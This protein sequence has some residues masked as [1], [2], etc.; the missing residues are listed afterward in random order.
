MNPFVK[1]VEPLDNYK[2]KLLF[3]NGDLKIF[4]VA[5]YLEKGVF[6]ELK[7][8]SYF[9]QVKVVS[10]AIEWPHEQDFSNDTLFLLGISQEH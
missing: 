1:S 6:R 5:P 10:G 8:S 2:L 9:K 4:D 7:D 3:T